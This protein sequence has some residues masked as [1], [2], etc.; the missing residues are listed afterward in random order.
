MSPCLFLKMPSAECSNVNAAV[1]NTL[2]AETVSFT[3]FSFLG[4]ENSSSNV[5]QRGNCAKRISRHLWRVNDIG[6]QNTPFRQW[7][8]R[9]SYFLFSPPS[10]PCLSPHL[11]DPAS[12]QPAEQSERIS[13]PPTGGGGI[14]ERQKESQIKSS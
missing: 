3:F 6:I 11:P 7:K 9:G 14:G 5:R 2:C 13:V 12:P 10:F 4:L 1:T 8:R